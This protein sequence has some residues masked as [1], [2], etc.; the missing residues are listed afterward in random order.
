MTGSGTT[1]HYSLDG[2]WELTD[3]TYNY[4]K[5][6]HQTAIAKE[7][8][9]FQVQLQIRRMADGSLLL[10]AG[11]F[12]DKR[13]RQIRVQR[14][15]GIS[16]F[17]VESNPFQ[18]SIPS[19]LPQMGKYQPVGSMQFALTGSGTAESIA[20]LDLQGNVTFFRRLLQAH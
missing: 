13:C 1:D 7:S 16:H 8:G 6:F 14:Q 10:L 5:C 19:N 12:E 20:D 18:M 17:A 9:C 4:K 15:S 2:D 11:F 3:A